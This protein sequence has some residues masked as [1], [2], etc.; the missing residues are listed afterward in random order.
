MKAMQNP[1]KTCDNKGNMAL[2]YA[3]ESG[4]V[5]MELSYYYDD[6]DFEVWGSEGKL[7]LHYAIPI[8]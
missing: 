2:D 3:E 4:N 8:E 5:K 7:L 6:E 1:E